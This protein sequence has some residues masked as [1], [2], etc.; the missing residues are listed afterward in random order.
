MTRGPTEVDRVGDLREVLTATG[1][2]LYLAN[3]V[4]GPMPA[5][6]MAAVH[7]SDD[8]ELR[9]GRAGPDREDDIDQREKEA[10]A[11][12]AAALKASPEHVALVHGA[13]EG[14]R[15]ALIDLATHGSLEGRGR[16]LCQS[17]LGVNV[18][19]AVT[20]VAAARGWTVDLVED[21][22]DV[23]AAD[24][25]I[26]V[27]AHVDRDG[28]RMDLR[29]I[30]SASR[31]AGARLLVDAS[32]SLGASPL[33]VTTD[34]VDIVVADAH[35]W[36]LAPEGMGLAWVSP[37]LD[38]EAASRLR[39]T[40]DGFGRGRLLGLA[41][42]V[43]WLLMYIELPWVVA[44]TV[45][46]ADRL[47]GAL[48]A[49]EG[50]SLVAE[51]D[52]G[53]VAAFGIEDWHA[54]EAAEELSRGVFAIVEVDAAA[55]LVRASVGAWNREQEV[56]RFVERVAELAEHTPETLPRKPSLTVL[57]DPGDVDA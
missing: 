41:R 56:D 30:S 28:R 4:A 44:R 23:I 27:V 53:A 14:V 16:V 32:F 52:H 12:V 54:D 38:G 3:H 33:D 17:S 51:G 46:L 39:A 37:A 35:R 34:E 29:R 11:V 57:S 40:T 55:D 48:A 20:S 25:V 19:G 22:P 5:E 42:S 49:V 6:S 50:V 24:V 7:E 21:L 26:S 2:G 43:G 18:V 31:A 9:I 8:L 36:L 13:G 47:Y 10:R 15:L 1:A 45:E